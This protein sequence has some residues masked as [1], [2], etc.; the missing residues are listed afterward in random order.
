MKDDGSNTEARP[1]I[2]VVDDVAINLQV[3]CYTL[4]KEKYRIAVAQNGKQA[5]K[6]V[7]EI[8]PDLILLDVMMPELNGYEVCGQLKNDPDTCDIPIIF[9]TA[10][11]ETEDVI[12]G[13]QCGAVDYVT[14]P[15]NGPEILARVRTHLELKYYRELSEKKET[16]VAELR[17]KLDRATRTDTLTG[18]LNRRGMLERIR[19]EQ[20][21]MERSQKPFSLILADVDDFKILNKKHGHVGGDYALVSIGQ[22]IETSLRKQDTLARWGGKEFLI[23]LPETDE[24]G[25]KVLAEKMKEVVRQHECDYSGVTLSFTMT[26]G[27]ATFALG[28]NR[29]VD[30]C[31]KAIDAAVYEGK[32]QGK[33]CVIKI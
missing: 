10:K 18:L 8:S 27:V 17:E 25:A 13:F 23:L 1:L 26:F 24:N 31:L 15:I 29:T 14:K 5:L 6:M 12:K 3:L 4:G 22:L 21:R 19:F 28:G 20:T 11:S 32:N 9:L 16:Q 2:L 7:E 30:E 33:N